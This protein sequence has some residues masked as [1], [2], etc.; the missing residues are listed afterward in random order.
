MI[1]QRKE[2]GLCFAPVFNKLSASI[3]LAIAYG[4]GIFRDSQHGH[5]E[6]R[7]NR[8][9]AGRLNGCPPG[10]HLTMGGGAGACKFAMASPG[11]A[12]SKLYMLWSNLCEIASTV[13]GPLAS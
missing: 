1:M 13:A 8:I 6:F 12:D 10:E 5:R 7:V 4:C 11:M 3:A 9:K 2:R